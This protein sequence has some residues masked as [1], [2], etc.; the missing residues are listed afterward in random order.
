MALSLTF[1]VPVRVP[2]AVGVKVTL[3]AHLSFAPKLVVH[4]VA[5]TAKS[6]VVEI[7]MLVSVT[8]WLLVR[9][10]VFAV[11]V[12]PTIHVPKD[13]LVGVNVAGST[14]VPDSATVCGLLEALSVKL[15]VPVRL[16][17]A[18]GVKVTLT[19]HVLP[20][21]SRPPHVFAE[22]AKLSPSVATELMLKGAAPLFFNITARAELVTSR[23]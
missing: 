23:T 3:T 21:P 7:A 11:L 2:V 5:D 8:L 1:S 13:Q 6:P 10:N 16:P 4:V 20:R 22:I 12:V 19:L 17:S 14:P 15:S 9:L 18:V